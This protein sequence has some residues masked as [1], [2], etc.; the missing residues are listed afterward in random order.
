[1][2]KVLRDAG[3]K[4]SSVAAEVL[5]KSGRHMSEALI[6]GDHDPTALADFA[7]GQMRIKRPALVE[8]LTGHFDTHHAVTARQILDH[9]DFLDASIASLSD[10]IAARTAAFTP[11]IGLLIEIPGIGQRAAEAIIAETGADM[12]RFPSSAHLASW[13]GLC[14]GN[15]E[16]AGK[17]RRV[18][19]TN[20]NG[21]LRRVL[22]ESAHA[23]ARTKGSYFGAHYRQIARR[24][25]PNKAAVAV[26]HSL[27]DVTWH[28][29]ATGERFT[30]LGADHSQRRR[31]PS[32]SP[33]TS[34]TN[35]NNSA[36][37]SPSRLRRNPQPPTSLAVHPTC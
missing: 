13:V 28:I 34:S 22:I 24:R 1:L 14:P 4:L 35:S 25:G 16:S 31:D 3:I 37:R 26:A 32:G 36:T 33:G 17:R 11:A 21:W 9:V 12:T 19:T 7:I 20:G 15:H 18:G 10:Q 8:A 2:E 30:D 29:L 5:S 23:A 6:A 27:L